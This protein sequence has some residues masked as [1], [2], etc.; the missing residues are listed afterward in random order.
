M[1]MQK[2]SH[3]FAKMQIEESTTAVP[4]S[5]KTTGEDESHLRT[6][7]DFIIEHDSMQANPPASLVGYD[8][9]GGISTLLDTKPSNTW[10]SIHKNS[11]LSD[12]VSGEWDN[13]RYPSQSTNTYR[14]KYLGKQGKQNNSSGESKMMKTED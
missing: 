12:S 11:Q 6:S 3:D 7:Q 14:D 10:L 1:T 5:L 8:H 4:T 13:N 9:K 2:T